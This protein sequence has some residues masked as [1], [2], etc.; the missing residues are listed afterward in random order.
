LLAVGIDEADFSS[1]DPLV[2]P[3]LVRGGGSGDSA[4]LLA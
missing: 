2:D 1:A 3:M 4:S